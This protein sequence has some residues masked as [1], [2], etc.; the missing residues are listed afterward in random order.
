M[1]PMISKPF[2]FLVNRISYTFAIAVYSVFS[3]WLACIYAYYF[4][5]GSI[6]F[7]KEELRVAILSLAVGELCTTV[8][9]YVHYGMLHP[10]G[11]SGFTNTIRRINR[12]LPKSIISEENI[13]IRDKDLPILVD[14]LTYLPLNNL[15]V[16][17]FY[18]TILVIVTLVA[19]YLTAKELSHSVVI[20]VGGIIAL[21]IYGYFTFIITEYLNAPA[22]TKLKR[23]LHAK[24]IPYENKS[25]FSLRIKFYCLLTL[26]VISM[27]TIVIFV[28]TGEKS[29]VNIAG[30]ILTTLIA[31]GFLIFLYLNS[32]NIS[33]GQINEA[34]YDL[35]S[36]GSGIFF[37]VFADRELVEFS[38][39]YNSA[40]LE[41]NDIRKNLEKRV[42]ERTIDL[43]RAK[44]NLEKKNEELNIK[45]MELEEANRRLKELD[46]LKSDFL[47][48][49]SHELRTPLTSVLGF[50]KLISKE[51]RKT[52]LP[53]AGGE[54]R[55]VKKAKRIDED[56]EIIIREGERLTRL[57]NDV[58]DLAKIESGRI[59]W[60]DSVFSAKECIEQAVQAVRGQF[61]QKQDVELLVNISTALPSVRADRD[62]LVQVLINLL[63][64][65]AKFTEKGQVAVDA[66]VRP[67]GWIEVSVRDTG[68]G[69]TAEDIDKVFDK[70]HQANK[71]DST[72]EKPHG[73]GLG[74]AICRQIVE[75]YG[76]R[77]W[78]ESEP[79]KGSRFTFVLPGIDG[80]MEKDEEDTEEVFSHDDTFIV[81]RDEPLVLIVD[82]DPGVR[83]FLVQ[84]LE[85]EGFGTITA[86]DGE[87]ALKMAH[88][89]RPD[90]ITMDILMPRMDGKTA[91]SHLRNDPELRQIP[92]VVISVLSEEGSTGWDAT[93][94]KPVDEGMLV[95]TIRG[96]LQQGDVGVTSPCM[97]LKDKG[98]ETSGSI[99]VLCRGEITYCTHEELW[100]RIDSGFEGTVVIPS[101]AAHDVD[102]E[103]LVRKEGVQVVVIPV[104][105]NKL[106]T[107]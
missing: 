32:I 90:L 107:H 95:R 29:V 72:S 84:V 20:L 105:H 65:A 53:M 67:D 99:L 64:N 41:I 22:S 18:A 28:R 54:V 49:V 71:G 24:G 56:L 43:N 57:I 38:S 88:R 104:A 37:P 81:K 100:E 92:V 39:H 21:T 17:T 70:F 78:V 76:G 3:A 46:S 8:S 93:I 52:F 106:Q 27:I 6:S 85:D 45:N 15:I 42:E 96:L 13:E 26:V 102:L 80:G 69:I 83:S 60:R 2:E 5:T 68:S 59:E 51:F 50:A 98:V 89:Y 55:I 58:L 4:V 75:H 14:A 94:K 73:T 61:A 77:I 7:G 9:H 63:N 36:G 23:L 82:D 62:R 11:F 10:F 91:I 97:V 48:S 40:V 47:S 101:A 86:S 44:E 31:N 25:I 12:L 19:N 33:L 74:L 34:T 16:A 66:R 30:F 1:R 103:R 87:S 79:G 35:A